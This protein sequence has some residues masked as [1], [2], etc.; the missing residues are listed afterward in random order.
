M[1]FPL[2]HGISGSDYSS[3]VEKLTRQISRSLFYRRSLL[4]KTF[5]SF[6]LVFLAATNA[7]AANAD[8]ANAD[9]A[10]GYSS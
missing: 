3:S 9:A 10:S 5:Y 2:H 1:L 8:P 4:N 7:A 6:P